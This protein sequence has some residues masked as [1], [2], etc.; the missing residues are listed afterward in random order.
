MA[1]VYRE[2]LAKRAD[3]FDVVAFAIFNAGYGPDNYTPFKEAFEDW[4]KT[5]CGSV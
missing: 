1:A 3:A 5:C 4:G 2:E